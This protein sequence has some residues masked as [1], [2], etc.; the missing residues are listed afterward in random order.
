MHDI[1]LASN[2]GVSAYVLKS[3]MIDLLLPFRA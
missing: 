3:S 1:L 2:L